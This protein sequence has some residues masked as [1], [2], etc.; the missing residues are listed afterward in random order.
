MAFY[1]RVLIDPDIRGL[2]VALQQA[3]LSANERRRQRLVSWPLPNREDLARDL[4]A[5]SGS[6]QW[7]GGEPTPRPGEGRSVVALA[8]WT[9]RAGRKHHRIVGRYGPFNRPMLENLLC[10][11]GDPRPPLW[12]VYPH[13]IFLKRAAEERL[14]QAICACGKYGLPEELGW[15][16]QS[17]DACFDL[18]EEGHRAT[19]AW[20]DPRKATLHAEEGRLMFLTFSPDGRTL[21]A[22]TGHDHVTLWDTT[23]GQERGRLEGDPDDWML[24][25][26]WLDGGQRLVT[27]D[28]VGRLRYW[29][30]RTGLA[31]GE[32]GRTGATECFAS[33][34]DGTLVSRGNRAGVSLL[35]ACDGSA[36]RDLEGGLPSVGVVAFSPDGRLVAAGSRDG[37]VAIWEVNTG[38]LEGKLDRPGAIVTGLAFAPDGEM[39]AVSLLPASGSSAPEASRILIFDLAGGEVRSSL[40]GHPGGTRCV[41]FAPDGRV[42]ASG[43]EDGLLRLWDVHAGAERVALEWHLDCVSSVAF[44]PDGLTLASG[45]FDGTVKLWP[46]E[47][48]RPPSRTR[49]RGAAVGR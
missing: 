19:P 9:D 29:S 24:G 4:D 18:G 16:G 20:L 12:F 14:P 2:D 15:M 34:P 13:H 30:G 7:N 35:S 10:P 11:F 26:A 33:S 3:V 38:K 39:L 6:R 44:A 32:I 45:S 22:G 8:W 40:L 48:L 21:A 36:V 42:L 28:A 41:A 5:P 23:T 43:G 46:R 27:A 31:T 25:V 47:V 1:D 49:Q 37:I 17:C